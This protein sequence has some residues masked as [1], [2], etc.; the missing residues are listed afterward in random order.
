MTDTL[1]KNTLPPGS[2][3]D[4]LVRE[5]TQ[6]DLPW[7]RHYSDYQSGGWWTCSLLGRTANA[8]DCVV[9]DSDHPQST[10]A[11][12]KLP[13]LRQLL[14]TLGLRYMTARLA[15]LDLGAVLWEHRDYQDLLP[16]PRHRMH[17][18]LVTNPRACLVCGGQR[19]HME[20]AALWTFRPT[21]SHG[22]CNQGTQPRTHLILDVYEDESLRSL[23]ACAV[24]TSPTALPEVSAQ[25]LVKRAV[26]SR[27][28]FANGTTYLPVDSTG[29]TAW[30]QAVLE[31]YF[32]VAAP[33][34]QVYRTL[35]Q[36][37]RSEGDVERAAF[38]RVR[39]HQ[40]LDYGINA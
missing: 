4:G 38:W 16:K 30:E 22:A 19:Y 3:F 14:Q 40:M 18:P 37:Y 21:A 29:P 8:T 26:D 31:L 10:D 5:I 23:L 12:E 1:L 39:R 20:P 7:T 6:A 32:E 2:D 36:V 24:G 15:R 13:A 35:E 17:L 28:N 27:E 34:G 33:E 25:D 9:I 11:L